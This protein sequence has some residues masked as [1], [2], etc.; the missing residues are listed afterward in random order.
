MKAP[1]A[2]HPCPICIV[3]K[4]ELLT[5]PSYRTNYTLSQHDLSKP[6]LFITSDRIVPT[7]LHVLLGIGNKI[8][9]DVLKV[10]ENEMQPTIHTL[11][12]GGKSDI[13]QYNG[14]EIQRYL[15]R[16][17][18]TT[19]TL[20]KWLIDIEKCLLDKITW[21]GER[22]AKFEKVVLDIKTN[23]ELHTK[24]HAFPKVHMLLHCPEFAKRWGILG[25]A[26]ESQIESAHVAFNTLYYK[27]HFNQS[28]NTAERLRRCLADMV[29]RK[30]AHK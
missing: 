8:I 18:Q 12:C 21:S 26:A 4:N 30:L 28:H 23:W 27:H 9:I 25:Y 17:V 16:Q 14:P 15:Q 1:A 6:L 7:P 24:L 29:L 10:N 2:T 3:N 11:G 5:T 22:I 13:Y 20:I 19:N